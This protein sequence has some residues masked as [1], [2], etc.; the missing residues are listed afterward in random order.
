MIKEIEKAIAAS[1]LGL[2]ARVDE[3]GLRISFPQLTSERR[4]L[5]NKLA[6]E[7]LEEARISL[8]KDRERVLK[9][10]DANEE[11]GKMTE[12]DVKRAK[13]ELQ[14]QVDE[15]NK[16]FDDIKACKEKEIAS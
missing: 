5:L 2:S 12:D 16:K 8:R 6:K 1:D 10:F 11:E 4:A 7:K 15:A 14:K 9:E 13:N 3:S